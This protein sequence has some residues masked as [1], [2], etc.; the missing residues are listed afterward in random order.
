ME[1]SWA[2]AFLNHTVTFFPCS[3]ESQ[4]TKQILICII[5]PSD[6][7]LVLMMFYFLDWTFPKEDELL[8]QAT[9]LWNYQE[10]KDDAI[11]YSKCMKFFWKKKWQSE[12]K[13]P[14]SGAWVAQSVKPPSLDFCSSHDLEVTWQWA[15]CWPCRACLGFS[16]PPPFLQ[17]HT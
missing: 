14:G 8:P 2:T 13:V 9:S 15:L 11:N 7:D 12:R 1:S 10:A 5:P 6:A 3:L 4:K 17:G 16:V